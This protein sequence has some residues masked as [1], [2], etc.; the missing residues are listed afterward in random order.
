MRRKRV[1][2]GVLAF[3]M[4]FCW[5]SRNG[6]AEEGEPHKAGEVLA[7]ETLQGIWHEVMEGQEHL[8]EI[9]AAGKLADV[10][11]QAFYIRDLVQALPKV[12]GMLSADKKQRLKQ[13]ID[14]VGTIA[15][16]LDTYGDSGDGVN[17]KVQADRL[18]KLLKYIETFYPK[19]ALND[20]RKKNQDEHGTHGETEKGHGDEE[21]NH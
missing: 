18:E 21:H 9:I 12:S 2:V 1:I 4:G 10:H 13:S 5:A 3:L 14:R 17:T 6:Y 11:K 15:K 20:V 19:G 16:L 8:K 7:P